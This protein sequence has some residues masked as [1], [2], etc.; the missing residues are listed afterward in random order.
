LFIADDS[1]LAYG[2]VRDNG[3]DSPAW[4]ERSTAN[5]QPGFYRRKRDRKGFVRVASANPD[6]NHVCRAQL[7]REGRAIKAR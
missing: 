7:G 5:A 4:A 2:I 1:L 3:S 6:F